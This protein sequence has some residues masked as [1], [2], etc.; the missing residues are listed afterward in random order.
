MRFGGT[1][2]SFLFLSS[3]ATLFPY[4]TAQQKAFEQARAKKQEHFFD[5]IF[6]E[7][8]DIA[9]PKNTTLK[10][11]SLRE[12]PSVLNPFIL[13]RIEGNTWRTLAH[14]AII[15][16]IMFRLLSQ[17]YVITSLDKKNF[18]LQTDWDKFFIDGRLFRNRM[19]VM[20]FPVGSRQTEVVVKN[21]VE[22]FAGNSTK[23]EIITWLPTPDITDEI[24]KLVEQTNKQTALVTHQNKFH[25]R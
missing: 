8:Q 20:V 10:E 4:T 5:H 2:L 21:I 24:Q 12:H 23:D 6:Q 3:C 7:E 16:R 13:T 25:S 1:F 18:T 11:H 14:P 15:F 19:S 22:Y 9:P 17:N